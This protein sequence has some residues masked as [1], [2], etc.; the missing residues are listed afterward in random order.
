MVGETVT[1]DACF[2]D[3]DGETLVFE[4]F[5]P[6]IAIVTMVATDPT[7]PKAQQSGRSGRPDRHT[8]S[9]ARTVIH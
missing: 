5:S 8:D 7:G 3:P 4:V 6:G 2:D 1:V 9:A